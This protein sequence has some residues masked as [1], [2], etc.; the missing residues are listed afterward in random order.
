MKIPAG[1]RVILRTRPGLLFVLVYRQGWWLGPPI[2]IW[3]VHYMGAKVRDPD[4]LPWLPMTALAWLGLGLLWRL[5]AWLARSYVLTDA[6][7]LVG[8]GVLGRA[9][10]DVPLRNIQRTTMTQTVLERALGLGT[11]GISTADGPAMNWLMI[12]SPAAAL[13]QITKAAQTKPRTLKVIGLAGGIGSGKSEV[14]RILQGLGCLV[15]DSDKEAKEALDRPEVRA[16]LV[17]W[18][19]EAILQ[20]DGRISR[21]A[22]A[23]IIFKD[24]AQRRRLEAL[25]HPLL[26]AKRAALKERA[27]AA[28]AIVIDAPLLFEAGVDAECD[29]VIFVD[30]PKQLRMDRIRQSRGWDEAELA[31]REASQLSLDLK[32]QRSGHTITNSGSSQELAA[33][34][35]RTLLAILGPEP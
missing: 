8:K 11:I 30:A 24:S 27:P 26:R 33:Q 12:P 7:L 19:G 6:R 5:L 23:D 21:K 31:R 34:V 32:R 4:P 1:E 10:G 29:T 17:K 9:A 25:V 28:R 18:W 22:V 35:R 16:E 3:I 13:E 20:P 14:A 15:V 2:A